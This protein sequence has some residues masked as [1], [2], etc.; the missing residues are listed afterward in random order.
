[1]T[2]LSAARRFFAE[3]IQIVAT[4]RSDALV[5]AL[6]TVPREQFLLRGPWTIRREGG[7]WIFGLR[8]KDQGLTRSQTPPMYFLA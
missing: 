3:E 4:L 8:T 5:D 7:S 2:D 1:M 6:A